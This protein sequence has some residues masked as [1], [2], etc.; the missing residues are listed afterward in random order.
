MVENPTQAGAPAPLRREGTE[1]VAALTKYLDRK[2]SVEI[3][4]AAG[5]RE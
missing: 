4:L 5:P 1:S 2:L 3:Y